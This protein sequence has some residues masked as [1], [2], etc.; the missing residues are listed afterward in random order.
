MGV[1][2]FIAF[3]KNTTFPLVCCNMDWS[4][5]NQTQRDDLDRTVKKSHI[6]SIDGRQIGIIGYL[7]QEAKVR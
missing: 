4:K 1:E 6:V 7:Y 2:K 5:L 3:A